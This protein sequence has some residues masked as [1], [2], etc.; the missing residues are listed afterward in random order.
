MLVGC[1]WDP[2]CQCWL[3]HM[4]P[5]GFLSVAAIASILISCFIKQLITGNYLLSILH[6]QE[7]QH[8]VLL[9]LVGSPGASGPPCWGGCLCRRCRCRVAAA[10]AAGASATPPQG[11]FS[12]KCVAGPLQLRSWSSCTEEGRSASKGTRLCRWHARCDPNPPQGTRRCPWVPGMPEHAPP[13]PAHS[14]PTYP[15]PP[16]TP[17]P[18]Q[19]CFFPLAFIPCLMPECYGAYQVEP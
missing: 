19:F 9:L 7:V 3:D 14:A 17:T 10:G 12:F 11:M 5:L 4:V 6:Q 8:F 15:P 13:H 18:A 16:P 2:C 1:C